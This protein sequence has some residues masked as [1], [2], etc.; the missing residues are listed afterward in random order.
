MQINPHNHIDQPLVRVFDFCGKRDLCKASTVCKAWESI[1]FGYAKTRKIYQ[2]K[3]IKE[4][5]K[6]NPNTIE[7]YKQSEDLF[8]QFLPFSQT[9]PGFYEAHSNL[10]EAAS[11]LSELYIAHVTIRSNGRRIT[12]ERHELLGDLSKVDSVEFCYTEK[13]EAFRIKHQESIKTITFNHLIKD[14]VTTG[15]NYLAP[16]AQIFDSALFSQEDP[17]NSLDQ[18]IEKAW[19]ISN[20]DEQIY[21]FK[22][23]CMEFLKSNELKKAAEFL[24]FMPQS[25]IKTQVQNQFLKGLRT[26]IEHDRK[27]T[28]STKASWEI[29]KNYTTQDVVIESEGI[30]E[31]IISDSPDES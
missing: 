14:V 25:T 27:W 28:E 16:I 9:V 5:L 6:S 7:T 23:I 11:C 2:I 15:Y 4:F 20:P 1:A 17:Q 19:Q 22:F 8:K 29:F 21:Y 24:K 10:T 30:L 12:D 26:Q 3:I 13:Q 18:F 31:K